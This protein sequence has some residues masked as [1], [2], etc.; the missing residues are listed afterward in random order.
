MSARTR[1]G[2]ARY[3]ALVRT[4]AGLGIAGVFLF[5]GTADPAAAE[6]VEPTSA[7]VEESAA[8]ATAAAQPGADAAA[9][10]S[11][12]A[13]A[14]WDPLTVVTTVEGSYTAVYGWDGIAK[15]A[16]IEGVG[17]VGAPVDEITVTS[18]SPVQVDYQ[19]ESLEGDR[20]V[21][22]PVVAGTISV[23]NPN[24]SAMTAT[25]EDTLTIAAECSIEA[26]DADAG[27]EGVQV[28][29]EPGTT[30]V[31]Y[32][33]DPD[34]EEV[35]PVCQLDDDSINSPGPCG[36][37]D[38]GEERGTHHEVTLSWPRADYP[39]DPSDA[40]DPSSA[41]EGAAGA[42]TEIAWQVEE[43]DKHVRIIDD[44][45]GPL[46]SFSW[47]G[48]DVASHEAVYTLTHAAPPG[49]CRVFVNTATLETEA[50]RVLDTDGVTIGVCNDA[51]PASS[52]APTSA[53]PAEPS[54]R[55]T[56]QPEES[57]STGAAGGRLP[58]TGA[59]SGWAAAAGVLLIA[60]GA[61]LLLRR[62]R[63]SEH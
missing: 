49:E 52:S 58:E 19:V 31:A 4:A 42:S 39:Q 8:P 51:E 25:V 9:D 3:S 5:G 17:E 18:D 14:L 32:S 61:V 56:S 48:L 54:A 43:H 63:S 59:G 60:S 36:W 41:P 22:D 53:A 33:C 55:P 1:G 12:E 44:V 20:E 23:T 38:E 24:D 15:R 47:T 37:N 30:E 27:A 16:Y 46:A 35:D 13:A 57:S 62:S 10:E 34:V 45:Q 21:S 26:D 50:G 28:S 7:T 40:A 2:E 6:E 29:F 11:A